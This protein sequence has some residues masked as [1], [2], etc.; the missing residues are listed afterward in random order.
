MKLLFPVFTA[1]VLWVLY[2]CTGIQ[3]T[4]AAIDQQLHEKEVREL[5]DQWMAAL[6]RRDTNVLARLLAPGFI[7]NGSNGPESRLQ[8]LQTTAMSERT[9]Q[10]MALSERH[11]AVW[12]STVVST[13][14]TTYAGNWKGNTFRLPVHYTHVYVRLQGSWQ[15]VAAHLSIRP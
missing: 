6:V 1:I 10:P 7:L 13:G 14:N 3:K 11:F 4:P 8:Y 2:S 12:G 5:E 9:L 15:V